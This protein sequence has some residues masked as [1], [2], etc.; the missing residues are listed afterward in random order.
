MPQLEA[1]AANVRRPGQPQQLTSGYFLIGK[2]LVSASEPS[3]ERVNEAQ[4]CRWQMLQQMT[5]GPVG[6][7]TTCTPYRL[8]ESG[9]RRTRPFRLA[10]SSASGMSGYRHHVD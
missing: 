6:Q 8:G 1:Y 7:G 2:L 5:C 9:L 10:S 4:L 3:L